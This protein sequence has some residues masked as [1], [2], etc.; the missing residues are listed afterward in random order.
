MGLSGLLKPNKQGPPKTAAPEGN[1]SRVATAVADDPFPLPS[2]ASLTK[3]AA[4]SGLIRAVEG[5]TG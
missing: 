4:D 1:Y 5:G 2:L 3:I